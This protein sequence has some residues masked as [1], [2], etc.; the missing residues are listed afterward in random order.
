MFLLV[1]LFAANYIYVGAPPLDPA[2]GLPGLLVTS[3]ILLISPAGFSPGPGPTVSL[4]LP[5][6]GGPFGMVLSAHTLVFIPGTASFAL[7]GA[8]GITI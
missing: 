6:T 3:P 5:A 7:T 2:F 8:V 1:G 4:P